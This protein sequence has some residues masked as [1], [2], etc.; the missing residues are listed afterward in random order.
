MLIP[1]HIAII[2]D[3]NNR[4]ARQHG[5]PA[6]EGHRKGV[7]A[8]RRTVDTA[9]E[10]GIEYITLYA[11]SVDNWKRSKEEVDSLMNLMREFLKREKK[12]IRDKDIR[13][14]VIGRSDGLPEDILERIEELTESTKDNKKLKLVIALNYGARSE[15]VDAV[16]KIIQDKV[17]V[18]N[19]DEESFSRY[20]YTDGIPDPDLFIRTS[21]EMRLSNFLLWQL[22]YTELWVTPAYWPDFGRKNIM[23]AIEDFNR[24]QRRFGGRVNVTQAD[25]K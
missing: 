16:K 11:F 24:R 25:N 22:S 17:P 19:V 23:E 12:E 20:L 14:I 13:L 18:D 10:L 1:R 3:G 15:I 4:W 2:M 6:M 7:E 21:G 8:I 9:L 5:L